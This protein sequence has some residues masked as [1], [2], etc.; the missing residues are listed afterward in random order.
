MGDAYSTPQLAPF[1]VGTRL[2][3]DG[4]FT[5]GFTDKDGKDVWSHT[6][7]V[8]YTVTSVHRGY[9]DWFPDEDGIMRQE[10]IHGCCYIQSDLDPDNRHAKILDV[11]N[12][13]EYT[14][15]S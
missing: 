15:L 7:G 6:A 1:P 14:P 13:H 5:S 4:P 10:T 9:C 2:R 12:L 11:E 8:M 3:Y